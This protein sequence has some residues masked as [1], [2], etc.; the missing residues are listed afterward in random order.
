MEKTVEHLV[1]I[2]QSTGSE[3][4]HGIAAKGPIGIVI[5][6]LDDR[7]VMAGTDSA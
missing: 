5:G 2:Q 7:N 3:V 6:E 4:P 1:V